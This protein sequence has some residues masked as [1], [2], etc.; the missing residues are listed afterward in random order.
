MTDLKEIIIYALSGSF[1][2][3]LG[4]VVILGVLRGDIQVLFAWLIRLVR[5]K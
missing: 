3:W 1:W 2:R 4:F 5:R